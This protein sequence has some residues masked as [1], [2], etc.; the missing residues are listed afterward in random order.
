VS[1]FLRH[2]YMPAVVRHA[3]DTPLCVNPDHLLGGTRADNSRDM[4]ERGRSTFG[5]RNPRAKLTDAQAN[6]IRDSTEQT[7]VLA[8]RF[9]VHRATIK[10]IR[11]GATWKGGQ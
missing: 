3:C 1:F 11:A 9:G 4:V 2:G 7:K 8:E 10:F 5:Q 6:E